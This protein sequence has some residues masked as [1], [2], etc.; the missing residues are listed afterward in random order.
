MP[1]LQP[2]FLTASPWQKL[3]PGAQAA[4]VGMLEFAIEKH[5]EW[6]VEATPAQIG[7][8]IGPE[9]GLGSKRIAEGIAELEAALLL[10]RTRVATRSTAFV[11]AAPLQR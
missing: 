7:S 5:G 2:A 4:L 6:T 8:W 1:T 3:S 11:I 10:R 9:S